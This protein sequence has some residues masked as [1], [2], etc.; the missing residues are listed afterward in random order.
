MRVR[1][2][3]RAHQTRKT[4]QCRQPEPRH[5]GTSQLLPHRRP[6]QQREVAAAAA[7]ASQPVCSHADRH[8]SKA[9]GTTRAS[10]C[11]HPANSRGPAVLD[12]A[13]APG[14]PPVAAPEAPGSS[15]AF[16]AEAGTVTSL[17]LSFSA[18]RRR[19]SSRNERTVSGS[20]GRGGGGRGGTG[21]VNFAKD[22]RLGPWSWQGRCL[23]CSSHRAES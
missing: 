17:S 4:R 1:G 16:T 20:W 22:G 12:T 14:A 23:P 9:G 3:S 19:P 11:S 6:T 15:P 8:G 5:Q 7:G 21:W 2:D 18:A 10:T 13:S